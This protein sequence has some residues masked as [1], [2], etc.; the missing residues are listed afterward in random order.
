MNTRTITALFFLSFC[1]AA[2]IF[3]P[4]EEVKK[5]PS[6]MPLPAPLYGTSKQYLFTKKDSA[7]NPHTHNIERNPRFLRALQA[8]SN[9]QQEVT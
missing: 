6:E 9:T 2:Y 3:A 7:E 1:A 4:P 5:F 8:K